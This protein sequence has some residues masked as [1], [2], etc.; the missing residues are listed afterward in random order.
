MPDG[1]E[2]GFQVEETT[3]LQYEGKALIPDLVAASCIR[4]LVLPKYVG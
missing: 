1:L 3:S 2:L 4:C